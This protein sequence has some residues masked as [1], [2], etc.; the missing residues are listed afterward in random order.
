MGVALLY[1]DSLLNSNAGYLIKE[2]APAFT[3]II[4]YLAAANYLFL[5]FNRANLQLLFY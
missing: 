4:Q 5:L 3:R 1:I 2:K